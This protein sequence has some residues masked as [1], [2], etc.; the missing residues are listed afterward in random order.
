M[1]VFTVWVPGMTVHSGWVFWCC[2]ILH[3]IHNFLRIFADQQCNHGVFSAK[4]R[5]HSI[6]VFH[7]GFALFLFHF[8]FRC[9]FLEHIFCSS[10]ICV[11]RFLLTIATI[12]AN[13]IYIV[14]YSL[15]WVID[16]IANERYSAF[17]VSSAATVQ[18]LIAR[19][20]CPPDKKQIM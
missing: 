20:N 4:L 7:L 17:V 18:A 12:P 19:C 8:G 6:M 16:Q 10:F 9:D 13:S 15:R 2:F 14:Q 5:R 1:N 11:I 3:F